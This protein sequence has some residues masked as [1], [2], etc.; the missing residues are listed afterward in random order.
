MCKLGA[1]AL[2]LTPNFPPCLTICGCSKVKSSS[3][4][5]SQGASANQNELAKLEINENLEHI[6]NVEW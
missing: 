3:A 2:S 5:A 6:D 1:L 4:T